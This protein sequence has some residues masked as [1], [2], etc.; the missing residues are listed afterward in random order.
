M[1]KVVSIQPRTANK[2][3]DARRGLIAKIHIARKQL[4]MEEDSYRAML[5][6]ITGKESSGDMKPAELE[7]VLKEFARLGFTATARKASSGKG[8]LPSDA[9]ARKIRAL[10]LNLYHLG[11]IENGAEEA[12]IAYCYRMSGVARI[13]W[14][15]AQQ[16]DNVIRGLLGWLERVG[17][18]NPSSDEI[19]RIARLRFANNLNDAPGLASKVATIRAQ[20]ARIGQSIEGFCPELMHAEDMDD[21]IAQLGEACRAIKGGSK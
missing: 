6:R 21:L 11:E 9:Q 2:P 12:L 15:H 16:F 20:C 8:G 14:M 4:A 18:I 7:A 1:V 5:K 19:S 13:E 17:W 3:F 10:W